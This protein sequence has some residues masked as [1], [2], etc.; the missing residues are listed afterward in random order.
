MRA[1]LQLELTAYNQPGLATGRLVFSDT[2]PRNDMT[3]SLFGMKVIT[4]ST[5]A[6]L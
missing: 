2:P 4:I 6:L 1:G 3:T 5:V